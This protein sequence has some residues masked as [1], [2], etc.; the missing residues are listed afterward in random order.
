MPGTGRKGFYVRSKLA[1]L[2]AALVLSTGGFVLG[3]ASLAT[4]DSDWAFCD[5]DSDGSY[6]GAISKFTGEFLTPDQVS[7]WGCNTD[8]DI[9][10]PDGSFEAIPQIPNIPEITSDFLLEP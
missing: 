8:R 4:A 7:E 6:V 2:G 5:Y 9:T 10:L 1:V 3:P